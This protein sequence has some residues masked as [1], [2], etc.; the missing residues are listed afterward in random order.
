MPENIAVCAITAT[1]PM[2]LILV[3][4]PATLASKDLKKCPNAPTVTPRKNTDS[5]VWFDVQRADRSVRPFFNCVPPFFPPLAVKYLCN[6]WR[7]IFCR[8]AGSPSP[9]HFFTVFLLLPWSKMGVKWS[10]CK[11]L[12]VTICFFIIFICACLVVSFKVSWGIVKSEGQLITLGHND[13]S[14]INYIYQYVR[15]NFYSLGMRYTWGRILIR[16]NNGSMD[17]FASIVEVIYQ[18]KLYGN[19]KNQMGHIIFIEWF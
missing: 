3:A 14:L 12:F 7:H 15:W 1:L 5:I 2:R 6:C 13:F 8:S 16:I 11:G 10:L 19:N 18:Y 4:H 17:Y 9:A